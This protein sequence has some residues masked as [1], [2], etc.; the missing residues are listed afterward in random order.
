[1]RERL[2]LP[3]HAQAGL[4]VLPPRSIN[5]RARAAAAGDRSII[6]LVDALLTAKASLFS[7]LLVL[8][9][10]LWKPGCP[11]AQHAAGTAPRL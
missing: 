6:S 7:L 2:A 3:E 11:V 10:F 8:S 1:M 5:A 4:P 9:V